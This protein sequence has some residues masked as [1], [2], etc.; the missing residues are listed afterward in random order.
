MAQIMGVKAKDLVVA[1]N[2]V[3]TRYQTFAKVRLV[4]E[5]AREGG[6]VLIIHRDLEVQRE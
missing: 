4:L 3:P 5:A 6:L 2:G 1:I